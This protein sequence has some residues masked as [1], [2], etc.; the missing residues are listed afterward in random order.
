MHQ[1]RSPGVQCGTHISH[2]TRTYRQTQQ[3]LRSTLG[4]TRLERGRPKPTFKGTEALT[5]P[6]DW[7]LLASERKGHYMWQILKGL[8]IFTWL[9]P[10]SSG[11]ALQH[12]CS[13]LKLAAVVIFLF[14]TFLPRSH[15]NIL[16]LNL[17]LLVLEKRR[18]SPGEISQSAVKL[19]RQE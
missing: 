19:Q 8:S 9:S 4:M 14:V 5:L 15:P 18:W 7:L 16:P 1:V 2:S 12:L 6:G 3:L 10:H 13:Q 11:E 17:F